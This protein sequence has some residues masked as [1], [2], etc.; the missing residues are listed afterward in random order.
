MDLRNVENRLQY[1]IDHLENETEAFQYNGRK[2]ME[3]DL[4]VPPDFDDEE[5]Q[6]IDYSEIEESGESDAMTNQV[7]TA[8]EVGHIDVYLQAM[9]ACRDVMDE[10]YKMIP[11]NPDIG[12][13]EYC[14][15]MY[16]GFGGALL[17]F[18]R[19]YLGKAV[20]GKEGK[21]HVLIDNMKSVLR[22]VHSEFIVETAV[23]NINCAQIDPKYS[24]LTNYAYADVKIT[25]P[26]EIRRKGW[27]LAGACM[28]KMTRYMF[29][30]FP[31][32]LR[33]GSVLAYAQF[34]EANLEHMIT[35]NKPISEVDKLSNAMEDMDV[36]RCLK[37][38]KYKKKS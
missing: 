25:D 13:C 35:A 34:I 20:L 32:K 18:G 6:Y 30:D 33:S 15:Y 28:L 2:D 11:G 23:I 5:D 24:K 8:T 9:R 21:Q 16:I 37:C 14:K 3:N 17:G 19:M 31:I 4:F 10:L 7:K 38:G 27:E 1:K 29:H 26:E 36:S 22:G 12:V